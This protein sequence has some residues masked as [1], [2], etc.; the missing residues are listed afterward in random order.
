MENM[1]DA[2]INLIALATA[3]LTINTGIAI[4]IRLH[5][6]EIFW[7]DPTTQL[8]ARVY[9]RLQAYAAALAI[10][11]LILTWTTDISTFA[12]SPLSG[13]AFGP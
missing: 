9:A 7:L 12:W 11:V 10:A 8:A 6:G 2:S 4:W 13:G 5:K 1:L 3:A